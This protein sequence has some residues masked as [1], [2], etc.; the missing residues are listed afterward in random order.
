VC[1]AL[2][3]LIAQIGRPIFGSE[4]RDFQRIPCDFGRND[5]VSGAIVALP[6]CGNQC[7][8]GRTPPRLSG[9]RPSAEHGDFS[10]AR[11]AY[12]QLVDENLTPSLA[13]LIENDLGTLEALG[14][15]LAEARSHFERALTLDPYCAIARQNLE[16]L[17]ANSVVQPGGTTTASPAGPIAP[18]TSDNRV[19]IAILSLLAGSTAGLPLSDPTWRS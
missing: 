14:E 9:P 4:S 6:G 12:Q 2:H 19:R 8:R 13:S 15:H 1:E 11:L 3:S 16:L 18:S 5:G 7:H 10:G 17:A